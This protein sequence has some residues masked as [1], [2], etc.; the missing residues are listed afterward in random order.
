MS[1]PTPSQA[2]NAIEKSLWG[3]MGKRLSAKD[4]DAIWKFFDS[5]CAYCPTKLKRELREGH[6]DHA[7]AKGGNSVGNSVLS[8][9]KCN[10]DLKLSKH[11]Q[12]FLEDQYPNDPGTV[13][14]YAHKVREWMHVHR[15]S[16]AQVTEDLDQ[17]V[18]QIVYRLLLAHKE[19]VDQ[20]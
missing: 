8:C 9:G 17:K 14:K 10:G 12:T 13:E 16:A 1:N 18:T 6:I 11:W 2:R 7:V 3:L 15:A 4:K 20:I 5:Q 19:A